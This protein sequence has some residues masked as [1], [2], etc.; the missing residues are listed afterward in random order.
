MNAIAER[1]AAGAAFLDEHDP[2]WWRA[3]VPNAIDLTLLWLGSGGRCILGQRCPLEAGIEIDEYGPESPY[4]VNAGRLSGLPAGSRKVS[5]WATP[6]GFE[7]DLDSFEPE[8]KH[9]TLEW[10]RTITGR[11]AA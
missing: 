6:L 8:Y 1:V 9:L 5:E 3:D 10:A 4:A 2:D 7:A 11:R